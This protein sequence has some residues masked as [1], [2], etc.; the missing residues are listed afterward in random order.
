M[1]ST[2]AGVDVLQELLK[3]GAIKITAGIGRA[4]IALG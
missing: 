2:R 4:V 3:G 1:T